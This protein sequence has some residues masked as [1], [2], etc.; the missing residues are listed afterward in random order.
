MAKKKDKRM[1]LLEAKSEKQI[2]RLHR[3]NYGT[4]KF[5]LITDGHSVDIFEQKSGESSKQRIKIPK[6]HFDLL[7]KKYTFKRIRAMR[8]SPASK[9]L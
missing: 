8:R 2:C 1:S 7:V 6:K 5:W 9:N 4:T 3:D